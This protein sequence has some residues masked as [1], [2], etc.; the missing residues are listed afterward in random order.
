[1]GTGAGALKVGGRPVRVDPFA[2]GHAMGG[3]HVR[4]GVNMTDEMKG[5]GADRGRGRG[6]V[7]RPNCWTH[8]LVED[9]NWMTSLDAG[10]SRSRY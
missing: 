5:V 3:G 10:A 2:R 1:M 8:Q 4:E 9:D 6:R 7:I